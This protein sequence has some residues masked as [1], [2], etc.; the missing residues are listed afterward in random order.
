MPKSPTKVELAAVALTGQG[1]VQIN[2]LVDGQLRSWF[3]MKKS[4]L[5]PLIQEGSGA[6]V[7]V[8]ITE[9]LAKALKS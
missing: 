3:L 8:T 2:V 7:E 5:R 4:E 6:S 9:D 1:R